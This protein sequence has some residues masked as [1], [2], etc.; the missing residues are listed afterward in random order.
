MLWMAGCARDANN[1]DA[2]RQ[3][4]IDHLSARKGLDLNLSNLSLDVKAMN[5][6]EN[7]ADVTMSF[8]PK[9]GGGGMTMQYSLEKKDGKWLVKKKQ[10]FGPA[11][12]QMAPP[13]SELPP[14]HPPMGQ[15]P[16]V[17]PPA[18]K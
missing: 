16:A 12:Q 9:G 10:D 6:R 11:H 14:G 1:K 2:I 7:E 15:P 18:A 8:E 13:P 17:H 3:A 4:V 5:I